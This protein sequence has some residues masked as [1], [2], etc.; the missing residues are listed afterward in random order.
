V[1][2][3]AAFSQIFKDSNGRNVMRIL[4]YWEDKNNYGAEKNDQNVLIGCD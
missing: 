1:I 2:S 3:E 4:H